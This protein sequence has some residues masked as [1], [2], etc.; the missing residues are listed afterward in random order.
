MEKRLAAMDVA[1]QRIE[2]CLVAVIFIL[3]LIGAGV[4]SLSSRLPREPA[5]SATKSV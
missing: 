2:R 3:V 5:R 1:L 4:M